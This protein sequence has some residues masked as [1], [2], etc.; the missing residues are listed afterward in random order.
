MEVILEMEIGA[1]GRRAAARVD[2]AGTRPGQ[3]MSIGF[4]P[5]SSNCD[6]VA[7]CRGMSSFSELMPPSLESSDRLAEIAR[8][9]QALR[10]DSPRQWGRMSPHQAV[11]HLSDALRTFLGEAPRP[12]ATDTWFTRSFLRWIGLHSPLRWPHGV[13]APR[14]LDQVA[15]DGTPPGV[16]E[17]DRDDLKALHERFAAVSRL[18]PV[19]AHPIFGPLTH[20]EWMVW[21]Y[22]HADHHLRQFGA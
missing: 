11:C 9:L 10:P 16:F 6:N 18:P 13:Q 8:R 19:S 7:K 12:P 20:D 21:A 5:Y 14:G 15:G 4:D 2:M 1:A 22:L 17:A 3:S